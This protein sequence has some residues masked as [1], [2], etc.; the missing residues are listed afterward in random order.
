[1][2]TTMPGEPKTPVILKT[3]KGT[4]PVNFARYETVL[5]PSAKTT[6]RAWATPVLSAVSRSATPPTNYIDHERLMD[7]VA[8]LYAARDRVITSLDELD[9]ASRNAGTPVRSSS[10]RERFTHLFGVI[11]EVETTARRSWQDE[12]RASSGANLSLTRALAV[13]AKNDTLYVTKLVS[14]RG[15][16]RN[17]NDDES[18]SHDPT[19]TPNTNDSPDHRDVL[20]NFDIFDPFDNVTANALAI[21]P[22][23]ALPKMVP[24]RPFGYSISTADLVRGLLKDGGWG[25]DRITHGELLK[26]VALFNGATPADADKAVS[27]LSDVELKLI[28]DDMDSNGLGN[29]EGLSTSQK[30]SFIAKLA[31]QLDAKQ[32]I[33]VAKAFNDD[34]Q[35]A[36]V[37]ARTSRTSHLATAFIA[38][39]ESKFNAAGSEEAKNSAALATAITV[40]NLSPN[41]LA[42]FLS[43][44]PQ[45]STYV[46]EVFKAAAKHTTSIEKV[47]TYDITNSKA[48]KTVHHFDTALLVK[49][50]HIASKMTA[51]Q[52]NSRFEVFQRTI[53]TL[54][55]ATDYTITPNNSAAIREAVLATTKMMESDLA[56]HLSIH[57]AQQLTYVEWMRQLIKSGETKK[58]VELVTVATETSPGDWSWAGYLVAIISRACARIEHENDSLIEVIELASDIAGALL[59]AAGLLTQIVGETAKSLALFIRS[60]ATDGMDLA[61][62]IEIAIAQTLEG[63]AHKLSR[64]KYSE[65]KQDGNLGKPN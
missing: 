19:R 10:P 54:K 34:I 9:A 5:A 44:H 30:E 53:D 23:A 50:N 25:T 37:L 63:P 59:N 20:D 35:I 6:P 48:D 28:A 3:A 55:W 24:V 45:P 14:K 58:L 41:D 62:L 11:R 1:M 47:D 8:Q 32:F 7:D 4:A 56:S 61:S 15:H 39:C 27:E 36:S 18:R 51:A 42:K 13:G 29:Y 16:Q 49:I 38:Y 31:T 21:K 60:K 2:T 33:R 57:S 52:E 64:I 65:G 46:T 17:A 40:A 22:K 12:L 43:A 26:L